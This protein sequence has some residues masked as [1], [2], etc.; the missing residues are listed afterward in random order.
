ME[1]W[2]DLAQRY[3]DATT[4]DDEERQLRSFITSEAGSGE[5]FNELRAVMGFFAVGRSTAKTAN[6]PAAHRTL[7]RLTVAAAVIACLAGG[8]TWLFHYQMQKNICVAYINGEKVTDPDIVLQQMQASMANVQPKSADITVDDQ[9]HDMFNTIN[10][11]DNS[12]H[13]E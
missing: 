1:Q 10:G 8:G 3:F 13:S 4:T 7:R 5:E 6:H 2:H 12:A 9:L 11:N